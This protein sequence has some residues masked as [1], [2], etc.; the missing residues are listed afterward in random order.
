MQIPKEVRRKR[1]TVSVDEQTVEQALR[2]AQAMHKSLRQ[3]IREYLEQIA[4]PERAEQD[5]AEFSRLAQQHEC[6]SPDGWKF[7]RQEAHDR[8]ICR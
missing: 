8:K 7:N 4:H 1:V 3:M 2:V 5:I 6:R